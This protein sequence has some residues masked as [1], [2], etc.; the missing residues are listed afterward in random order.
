MILTKYTW[1]VCVIYV[2]CAV[3]MFWTVAYSCTI[4]RWM[5][6]ARW[7]YLS[8]A[9]EKVKFSHTI[10][11]VSGN[12]SFTNHLPLVRANRI[13]FFGKKSAGDLLYWNFRYL[14]PTFWI[15]SKIASFP[16]EIHDRVIYQYNVYN[17]GIVLSNMSYYSYM[18]VSSQD[19]VFNLFFVSSTVFIIVC[20]CVFIK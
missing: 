11:Y 9:H 10:V 4:R 14:I 6:E 5:W 19:S 16:Q 12:K 8:L 2:I 3:C 7:K 13:V 17:I 15:L 18:V 20:A 1:H